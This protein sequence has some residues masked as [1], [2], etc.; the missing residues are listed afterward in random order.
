MSFLFCHLNRTCRL[1]FFHSAS[2]IHR[3]RLS[4]S[5]C[6]T[7]LM[8]LTCAPMG[9]TLFQPV[10]G[11]VRMTGCTALSAEP[12]FSG[13]PR[14]FSYSWK[15]LRSAARLKLGCSKV[16]VRVSR[17]FWNAGLRRS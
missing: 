4:L 8:C 11:F 3:S 10:M 17:N 5:S 16:A 6:V 12:M 1:W 9:N 15:P 7:P 2:S 13:A 14:G